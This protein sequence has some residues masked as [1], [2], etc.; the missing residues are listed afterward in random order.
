L[1]CDGIF[2]YRFFRNL[3]TSLSVKKI[4]LNRLSVGKVKDKNIVVPLF[5]WTWCIYTLGHTRPSV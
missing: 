2:N 5:F 4:F 1:R 3:L